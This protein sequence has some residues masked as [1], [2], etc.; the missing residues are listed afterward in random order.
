MAGDRTE[1]IAIMETRELYR[2]KYEAQLHEWSAKIGVLEAQAD[3]LTAQAK[4]DAKPHFDGLRLKLAAASAKLHEI[5][6]A[7]D[8]RWDDVKKGA[9]HVWNDFKAAVEGGYD[10]LSA[11]P[12]P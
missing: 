7:T 3:Q 4:I 1:R 8:D 10:A 11:K 6:E 9:D 5:A 2:Q 12:K